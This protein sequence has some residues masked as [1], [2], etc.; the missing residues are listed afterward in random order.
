MT[1]KRYVR[2]AKF[3]EETASLQSPSGGS[4]EETGY[5]QKAVRVKFDRGVCL[6]GQHSVR[7]PDGT[8]HLEMGAYYKWLESPEKKQLSG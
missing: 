5:T 1:K 7:A 8:I 6:E 4:A 2:I 3:A